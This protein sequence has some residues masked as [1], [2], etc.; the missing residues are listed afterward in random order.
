MNIA[1]IGY[2]KM[3]KVIEQIALQR[4]HNIVEKINKDNTTQLQLLLKDSN[5]D[6]AI[7]FSI[8]ESAVTNIKSCV[9][10]QVGINLMLTW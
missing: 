8:P 5:C 1:L 3:G 4:G 7:E 10:L 9:D 6:V 2:G